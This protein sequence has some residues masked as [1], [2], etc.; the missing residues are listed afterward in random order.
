MPN[1]LFKSTQGK[2]RTNA[3]KTKTNALKMCLEQKVMLR[4]GEASRLDVSL[5]FKVLRGYLNSNWIL[6][7]CY[8]FRQDLF[9]FVQR[10]YFFL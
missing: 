10:L 9:L 3:L 5:N 7:I 8:T 6:F 1:I 2:T 4:I